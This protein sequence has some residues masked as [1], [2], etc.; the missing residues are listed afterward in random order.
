MTTRKEDL[1][2]FRKDLAPWEKEDV[3]LEAQDKRLRPLAP[4]PVQWKAIND[5]WNREWGLIRGGQKSAQQSMTSVKPEID[6]LLKT[7]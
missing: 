2:A 5:I 6:S 7:T 1:E 4:L 3:Y